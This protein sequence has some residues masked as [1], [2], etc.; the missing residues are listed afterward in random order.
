MPQGTKGNTN[1]AILIIYLLGFVHHTKVHF[2]MNF[3][4]VAY[5]VEMKVL[6]F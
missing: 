5:K 4:P 2:E 1:M 6:T 3:Y